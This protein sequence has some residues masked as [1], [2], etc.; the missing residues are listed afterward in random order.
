MRRDERGGRAARKVELVTETDG[1]TADE[2]FAFR[3]R[4]VIGI[5][6]RDVGREREDIT[7]VGLRF[8]VK[9]DEMT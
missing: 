6:G 5:N 1:V 2:K 8:I 4:R 9:E 3:E 7:D